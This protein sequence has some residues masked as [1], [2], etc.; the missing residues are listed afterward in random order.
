MKKIW[1]KLLGITL[2][3]TMLLAAVPVQAA[4]DYVSVPSKALHTL[5]AGT[6]ASSKN[7]LCSVPA[8][9]SS[10]KSSNTSVA[11]VKQVKENW[12]QC[13]YYYPK[14]AG[15]TTVSFKYGSKTYKT[16]LTVLKY[17]N[18]I[19]S[20]TIGNTKISSSKFK[21]R[22][23]Y[24]LKYSTFANKK[25]KVNFKLKSGW[26]LTEQFSWNGSEI[27]S[28]RGFQYALNGW[29]KT[30]PAKNNSNITIKNGAGAF[31][32]ATAQNKSTGQ[33]VDIV[34]NLK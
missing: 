11:T 17:K 28:F 12:G 10:L 19:S 16:V 23:T 2:A 25:V 33:L 30:D 31:I 24:N 22:N 18:P 15:K 34:I 3:L 5:Y 32:M 1:K 8:K 13:I 21:S 29:A 27:V 9:V 20:I 6:P 7:C 4:G 14:K 26:Q